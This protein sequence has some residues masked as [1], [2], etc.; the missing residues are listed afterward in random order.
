M[1]I[2]FIAALFLFTMSYRAYSTFY[3]GGISNSSLVL[4]FQF[5]NSTTNA[6]GN[7]VWDESGT[8]NNG[9]MTDMNN[10]GNATS[11]WN[12]TNSECQ[13]GNCMIFDG[14]NDYVALGNPA[15]LRRMP[16]F[17]ISAWVYPTQD[18]W[19]YYIGKGYFDTDKLSLAHHT[20]LNT[21]WIAYHKTSTTWGTFVANKWTY[22]TVTYDGTNFRL[23][24]NGVLDKTQSATFNMTNNTSNWDIGRSSGDPRY[25]NGSIDDV[26][27]YNHTLS[28]DE[29]KELYSCRQP[30]NSPWT[31]TANCNIQNETVS[32]SAMSLEIVSKGNLT[33][34]NTS[35]FVDQIVIANGGSL[36]ADNNSSWGVS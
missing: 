31:M 9:T 28:L 21:W 3:S 15:T 14:I 1:I 32:D 27:I 11:G 12:T 19:M 34:T 24:E 29:I 2:L 23:Y 36:A 16:N 7:L 33:L 8:G 10:T 17:S 20:S 4:Y 22:L 25:W 13:Y 5:T 18:K 30:N 26:R 6:A 35:L